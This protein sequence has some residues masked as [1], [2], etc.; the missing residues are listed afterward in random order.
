MN[1]L[2][3]I[4]ISKSRIKNNTQTI[5]RL[6]GDQV[7]LA[8]CVK[9]N[10]YG[11]G[12]VDMSRLLLQHGAD[13][14]CVDSIEEAEMLRERG[15]LEPLLIM[16]YVQEKDLPEILRLDAKIF[17]YD[18][19]TAQA[20]SKIAQ[21]AGK[22]VSVHI[23]VDTGMSRQGILAPEVR[24]FVDQVPKLQN[25]RL[26]GIATHFAT[27]DQP[28]DN[29]H[30]RKQLT[31]FKQIFDELERERIHIPLFHCS[32]SAATLLYPEAHFDLVRPGLSI[33]GYYPS[34]AV[35]DLCAQRSIHLLPALTLKTKI[36]QIREIP[37]GSCISYGCTFITERKT[38]IAI[39]PIGYY[40]GLDRKL[41]N[42]GYVLINGRRASILGRV[43][44]NITIVDVTEMDDVAI[45]DE[46]VLIGRQG[47]EEITVEEIA[48]SVG[49]INYEIITRLRETIPRYYVE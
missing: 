16:G 8:P 39:L 37:K 9:A 44:M 36:A 38:K 31:A 35:R 25:L 40:D 3:W 14:L 11:H 41:S 17:L 2:I 10:A 21:K 24:H 32:N 4:E 23:K 12:I 48:D 30:F 27:S 47:S 28:G 34:Q 33:Y 45:E 46:V 42:C 7:L 29:A 15:I 20:L 6:I 22:Q 18:L 49:T 1:D 13:W 26:E 43:C 5:R 19:Q